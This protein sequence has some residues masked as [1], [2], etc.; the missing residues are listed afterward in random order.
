[1]LQTIVLS[2]IKQFTLNIV[3]KDC[4]NIVNISKY[5]LNISYLYFEYRLNIV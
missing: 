5:N 2:H 3:L 4:I 1:M